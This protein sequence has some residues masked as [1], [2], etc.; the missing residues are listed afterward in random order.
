MSQMKVLSLPDWS[1]GGNPYQRE[2]AA[3]LQKRGV[4]VI[5]GNGTDRLPI[6]GAI[7]VHGKP[8]VLHLHWTHPFML[9]KNRA[10]SIMRSIRFLAELFV[11]KL[12]GIKVVWTVH[13]LLE[14][15]RRDPQL[16]LLFNRLLVRLYDQ[17]IVHC[18][19]AREAVVQN[20]QLPDRF[21]DRIHV[22][23]HGNYMNN[24]ENE[25][26]RKKARAKLGLD[27]REIVFLY[28][29]TIRANKGVLQMTDTFRKFQGPRVRLLIVGEP[30]SEA[31]RSKIMGCCKSDNR[32]HAF[33]QFVPAKDV[34]LYMNAADVVVLPFQDILTSGSALLAMSFGKPVIAPRMGC[35]PEVLDSKGVFLYDHKEEY[36]L[37]RAIHQA[38]LANLATMGKYNYEKAKR[39]DWNVIAQKTCALYQL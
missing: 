35:I 28:F 22:I 31:I 36:G 26:P 34:Q 3:A 16:E 32:I 7:R 19:F 25:V 27:D 18:S 2:L 17:I 20:Y 21:K 13:N 15:E 14:H 12:L 30:L 39:F 29:G 24:Y 11:V 6:L 33:L 8:N 37:L 9:G 5:M 1:R 4:T 23:P 38:S 10:K